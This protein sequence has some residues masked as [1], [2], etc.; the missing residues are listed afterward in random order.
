[1]R[2]TSDPVVS[3]RV[4]LD[5]WLWAARFY[6]T[7]TQA[8]QAVNGG[9]VQLNGLRGKPA[10]L[11]RLGDRVEIQMGAL[12]MELFVR[13]L[14]HRRGP[15]SVAVTLYEETES[16]IG[17]REHLM[18]QLRAEARLAHGLASRGRPT[19][20]DRRRI[21]RFVRSDNS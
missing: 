16:S 18:D 19:K 17:R 13:G 21:V 12:K 2:E 14:S 9:K 7:R 3:D 1:M 20:R 5:R 6:K 10:K 11:I 8:G 4:R 15:A